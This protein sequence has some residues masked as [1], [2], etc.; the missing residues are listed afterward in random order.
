VE[1]ASKIDYI[2]LILLLLLFFQRQ[3]HDEFQIVAQSYR[4]SSAFTNKVFFAMVDFDDGAD[5]FQYVWTQFV[6]FTNC[7]FFFEF[8]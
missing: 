2:S 4:Y 5:V 7:C 3:A 8:S 1:Y 6:F